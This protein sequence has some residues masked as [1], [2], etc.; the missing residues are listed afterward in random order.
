MNTLAL[1]ADTLVGACNCNLDLCLI[2]AFEAEEQHVGKKYIEVE[3]AHV[4]MI[5]TILIHFIY[6]LFIYNSVKGFHKYKARSYSNDP[7][8][9][10]YGGC[11]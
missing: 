6:Y 10:L 2:T 11:I 7:L 8:Y 3:T 5:I 9:I 4:M 1:L